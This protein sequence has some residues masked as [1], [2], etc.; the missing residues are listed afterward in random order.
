M[1]ATAQTFGPLLREWRQRR[2]VSQLD[3]AL[4]G[5][6]SA[7]HLSFLETGRAR[8]SRDMV[9]HLAEHLAVPLRERNVLLTA[10]GYAPVFGERKLD[11]P[12]L[13]AARRAVELVIQRH[14]PYPALAVDRHW[15][16]IEANDAVPPLLAGVDAE[17]L[18]PPVNV[19]RLA[20][21]PAGIAP[22]IINFAEWRGHL[23]ERLRRQAEASADPVLIALREELQAYPTPGGSRPMPAKRDYA[24]MIVPLELATEAGV[25]AFFSTIT[26][27]GTPVDVT[28]SEIALECFY[29]ADSKTAEFLQNRSS[30]PAT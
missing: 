15:T 1:S 18:R 30:L 24:G 12:A 6:V 19:M 26:V 21:H 17:L 27:F 13:A 10:A 16:L 11:D 9:L 2:R 3:L 4:E 7:R 23:L 28:L 29:P 20:L 25:L 22:R 14:A 5:N 8:P